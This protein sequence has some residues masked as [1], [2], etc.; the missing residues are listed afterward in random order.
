MGIL[1]IMQALIF[2]TPFIILIVWTFWIKRKQRLQARY[3]DLPIFLKKQ[4]D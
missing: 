2:L 4:A 1:I 3:D